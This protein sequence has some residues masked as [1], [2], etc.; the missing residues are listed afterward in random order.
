MGYIRISFWRIF[1]M[2]GR[3]P[4]FL[5]K[6][7]GKHCPHQDLCLTVTSVSASRSFG[8]SVQSLRAELM[9]LSLMDPLHISQCRHYHPDWSKRKQADPPTSSRL[10]CCS[11]SED[12]F[13]TRYNNIYLDFCQPLNGLIA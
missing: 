11:V 4:N 9:I 6:K 5:I 2:V 1:Q 13:S 8:K 3:S 10:F 12:F 7:S